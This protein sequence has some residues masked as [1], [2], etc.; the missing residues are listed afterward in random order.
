MKRPLLLLLLLA[1]SIVS[2]PAQ[3][4]SPDIHA[5][6]AQVNAGSAD[7]VREQL[8]AL[9]SEHPNDPGVLYL[10]ALLTREGADA[11]RTYQSIVDNFPKDEWADD[12]L[13]KVYQFYYALGLYRTADLKMTQ[14]KTDYPASP[15]LTGESP[16]AVPLPVTV[17]PE[18]P[19]AGLPPPEDQLHPVEPKTEPMVQDP[20]PVP[21]PI[22]APPPATTRAD[23]VIHVRFSLQVG[24]F[25]VHANA[26]AEKSRFEALGYDAEMLSKV[27]DT[28]SLFIVMIGNYATYDEAKTAAAEVKRKVGVS[29]MVVSR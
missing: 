24:A 28:K 10:Q 8:P 13:F 25:T 1:G 27:R 4:G 15:L 22:P 29:A 21:V 26:A 23:S 12:A 20:A 14:L 3:N 6:V 18:V 19:K 5:L 17:A 2:A 9:L 11:V 7:A 16:A